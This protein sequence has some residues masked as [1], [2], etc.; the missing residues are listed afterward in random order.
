MYPSSIE[1]DVSRVTT[2]LKHLEREN[3]AAGGKEGDSDT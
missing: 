2:D 3:E 1:V